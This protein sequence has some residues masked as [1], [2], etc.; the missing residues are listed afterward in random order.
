MRM[1]ELKA[2]TVILKYSFSRIFSKDH[3]TEELDEDSKVM[4]K[5]GYYVCH[6]GE[7]KNCLTV[8]YKHI[9]NLPAGAKDYF[10]ARGVVGRE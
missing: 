9:S 5:Q 2:K 1:G 3:A 7:S 6:L 10:N 4:D 8:T